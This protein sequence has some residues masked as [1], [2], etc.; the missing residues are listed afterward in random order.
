METK[1]KKTATIGCIATLIGLS[2]IVQCMAG[3]SQEFSLPTISF[4]DMLESMDTQNLNI[5]PVNKV[6]NTSANSAKPKKRILRRNILK[7]APYF[8]DETFRRLLDDEK[9]GVIYTNEKLM[10]VNGLGNNKYLLLWETT[11]KRL[12][13]YISQQE[14]E[15]N[16]S[17]NR[18][19]PQQIKKCYEI[20]KEVITVIQGIQTVSQVWET[21]CE[22]VDVEP[23]TNNNDPDNETHNC[24]TECTC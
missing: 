13:T 14:K 21:I 23:T 24:V 18:I 6:E 12:I 17:T 3:S 11:D 19:T 4:S 7:L 5:P 20:A 22:W 10:L 1:F 9:T 2:S 15:L 8:E 16:Q